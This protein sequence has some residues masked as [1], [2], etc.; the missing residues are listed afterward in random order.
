MSAIQLNSKGQCVF[1]LKD[2]LLIWVSD[3]NDMSTRLG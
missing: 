1:K 3:F 2:N